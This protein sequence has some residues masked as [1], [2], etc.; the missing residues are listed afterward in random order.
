MY[1]PTD[2]MTLK[3]SDPSSFAVLDGL[4]R[5]DELGDDV[6]F[7]MAHNHNTL[8]YFVALA[9]PTLGTAAEKTTIKVVMDS[10]TIYYFD[11]YPSQTITGLGRAYIYDIKELIQ[12]EIRKIEG[13]LD[14]SSP[15]FVNLEAGLEKVLSV[16]IYVYDTVFTKYQ[17]Y[18]LQE[19]IKFVSG[20]FQNRKHN[21]L[22]MLKDFAFSDINLGGNDGTT[23][24]TGYNELR[25]GFLTPGVH[26]KAWEGYPIITD[27]IDN[28]SFDNIELNAPIGSTVPIVEARALINS[29]SN[30]YSL[31]INSGHT[32][33]NPSRIA[34]IDAVGGFPESEQIFRLELKIGTSTVRYKYLYLTNISSDISECNVYVRF[35]NS[36]GT[37]SFW[38]FSKIHYL[39]ETAKSFGIYEN[40]NTNELLENPARYNE[41]GKEVVPDLI[42]GSIV[43][44]DD[45]L[46]LREIL[47][48]A[49]VFIYTGERY[50]AKGLYDLDASEYWEKV[51]IKGGSEEISN[52]RKKRFDF[53][54]NLILDK[55]YN[56]FS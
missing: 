47:T 35:R 43:D 16:Y 1:N 21:N 3:T 5:I 49:E 23:C 52:T 42:V 8:E 29:G 31:M 51:S 20:Y 38:L 4:I 18:T 46:I 32:I 25:K 24:L 19:D 40:I 56:H 22:L 11:V 33:A 55:R 2:G 36:R 53:G 39:S 10:G 34:L 13:V 37:W 41:I 9:P 7:I 26:L 17:E 30:M 12:A 27:F 6:A 15:Y 54:I 50:S 48:S 28:Q 44:E 14:T 45:L